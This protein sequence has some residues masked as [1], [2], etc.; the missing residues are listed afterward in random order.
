[1]KKK[2]EKRIKAG[3]AATVAAAAVLMGSVFDTPD[4]LSGD[5]CADSP[6]AITDVLLEDAASG[7]DG[8]AADME[9]E[10]SRRRRGAAAI[11]RWFLALPAP[12]RSLVGLPLWGAGRGILALFSTLGAALAP[13]A[14]KVLGFLLTCALVIAAFALTAKAV[15]PDMPLKKILSRKNLTAL[16]AGMAALGL[17]DA[18][19]PLFWDGWDKVA[20]LFSALGTLCLLA[21]V[22]AFFVR[23]FGGKSTKE[24]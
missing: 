14:G 5:G 24:N 4:E 3:A 2:T 21:G 15:C 16:L 7:D 6:A 1:M 9:D 11:R 12:V 17:A 18:V 13:A 20:N 8:G 23:R 22:T 10:D 19:V